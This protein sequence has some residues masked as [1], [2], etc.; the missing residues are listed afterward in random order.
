MS[1]EP[2]W[3]LEFGDLTAALKIELTAALE[4]ELTAAL[5]VCFVVLEMCARFGRWRR[6]RCYQAPAKCYPAYFV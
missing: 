6:S 5:K 4:V 2:L 1:E 3:G